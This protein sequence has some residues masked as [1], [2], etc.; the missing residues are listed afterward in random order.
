VDALGD[1]AFTPRQFSAIQ[2]NPSLRPM[3]RGNRIDVMA[4]GFVKEDPALT[5]LQSSYNRGPDFVDPLTGRWWDMT[6]PGQW[7][8]HV[9]KYGPGGTLLSTK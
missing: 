7:P 9:Q 8:A 5:F 2:N 4:R 1:A 3:Y 6:T